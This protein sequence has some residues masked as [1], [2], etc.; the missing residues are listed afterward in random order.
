M[1]GTRAGDGTH[2]IF[3]GTQGPGKA[4]RE[5][6]WCLLQSFTLRSCPL[7]GDGNR[8]SA[9]KPECAASPEGPGVPGAFLHVSPTHP[10]SFQE[11]GW[12]GG[13]AEVLPP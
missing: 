12:S 4:A 10:S 5:H 6:L 11:D 9:G 1:S 8:S 3:T 2:Q 13:A 7:S